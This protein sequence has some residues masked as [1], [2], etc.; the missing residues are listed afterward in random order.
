MRSTGFL[1]LAM[2]ASIALAG[3][4]AAAGIP[5]GCTVSGTPAANPNDVR[6][7]NTTGGELAAGT[8]IKWE[9]A[10]PHAGGK[11]TLPE[12]LAPG[13][14]VSVVNALIVGPP[15]GTPCMAV[16]LPG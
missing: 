15:S 11:I 8:R 5:L 3:P 14:S 16:V 6:I 13:E 12:A 9:V 4:A 1:L 2:T 7:V 10:A